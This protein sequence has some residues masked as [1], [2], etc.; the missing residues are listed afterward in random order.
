MATSSRHHS[1]APHRRRTIVLLTLVADRRRRLH[2]RGRRRDP[3]NRAGLRPPER[4]LRL[5][6]QALRPAAPRPRR[7]RRPAHQLRRPADARRPERPRRTL[8]YHF[9]ASTS[10][11]PPA[12]PS[13]RSAPAS[14]TCAAARPSSSPPTTATPS[15]TGTSS[16]SVREGQRVTA[17]ETRARPD[18]S[19]RVR[20]RPPDRARD[21]GRP[22]NPL[23]PGHLTPYDDRTASRASTRRS[24]LQARNGRERA[25]RVPARARSAR[26]RRVGR[27]RDAGARAGGAVCRSSPRGSTWRI[28]R[29]KDGKIVVRR[30]ARRS[31]SRRAPAGDAVLADVRA[32]YAAEHGELRRPQDVA[33]ARRLPLPARPVRSTRSNCRT[34]STS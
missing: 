26:R 34:T 3:A 21:G 12:P 16:P 4:W 29:A 22:V 28:E 14:S 7:L 9:R 30:A 15:S 10:R 5:A 13:T 1:V 20:A 2:R 33:P 23:A 6:A 25:A 17:F 19:R 18:P 31:T 11:R 24:Y 32:R 8:A 27:H